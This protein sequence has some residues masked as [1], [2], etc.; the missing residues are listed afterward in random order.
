MDLKIAG[1]RHWRVVRQT[2]CRT[3]L[4]VGTNRALCKTKGRMDSTST[5][6]EMIELAGRLGVVVR[7][8]HLGGSGGGLVRVKA[9]RQLF[10]DQDAPAMDQLEQTARALAGLPEIAEIYVRPD[11]R[12]VL[13]DVGRRG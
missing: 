3:T 1:K 5:F 7:H 6:D 9:G 13:E 8:A 10:I 4:P 12:E 11:V 2:A